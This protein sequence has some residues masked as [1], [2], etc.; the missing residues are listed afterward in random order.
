MLWGFILT[1]MM[2]EISLRGRKGLASRI[3][4]G[5]EDSRID[6]VLVLLYTSRKMIPQ[7]KTRGLVGPFCPRPP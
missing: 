5:A 6:A 7:S 3:G 4:S 1:R 2:A